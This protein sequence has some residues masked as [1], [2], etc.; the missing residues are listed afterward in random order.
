M[1]VQKSGPV[2]SGA[3]AKV[4]G[5]SARR[6]YDEAK[7]IDFDVRKSGPASNADVEIVA[8]RE[9]DEAEFNEMSLASMP[10]FTSGLSCGWLHTHPECVF[11]ACHGRRAV[12]ARAH[13]RH[14]TTVGRSTISK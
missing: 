5:T 14:T 9:C 10:A 1:Y 6:E 2:P 7:V 4:H 11:E 8:G 12:L 3:P 13:I